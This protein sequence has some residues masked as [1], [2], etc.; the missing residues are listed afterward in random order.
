MNRHIKKYF[1]Y[2]W[3]RFLEVLGYYDQSLHFYARAIRIRT[4]FLDVQTRYKIAFE[5]SSRQCTFELHG[6]I[7][8]FLQHLPFLLKNKKANYILV[9]HFPKAKSFFE[10]LGIKIRNYHFYKL[11]KEHHVIKDSLKENKNFYPAP[12][13]IFFDSFPFPIKQKNIFQNKSIPIIGLHMTPSAMTSNPL[14]KELIDQL[15]KKLLTYPIKIILFGTRKELNLFKFTKSDHVFFASHE[16]I[17][18]NL[19]LVQYCDAMIGADSVFKTMASMAKIPTILFYED[20]KSHF[21]D[22]VFIN[23]YVKEKI[24]F[25]YKYQYQSLKG[26]RIEPAIDFIMGILKNKLK[27]I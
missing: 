27:L 10:T 25:P 8:D 9:T 7:G 19:T 14:S 5:K 11:R 1:F 15:I 3:G 13:Q 20:V 2:I 6:G 26:N 17:I 21:R 23:P 22:R 4:F 18:E 12:R 16:N 24:I